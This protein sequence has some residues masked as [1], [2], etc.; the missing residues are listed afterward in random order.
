MFQPR[1]DSVDIDLSALSEGQQS[2]FYLALVAAVFDVERQVNLLRQSPP[3]IKHNSESLSPESVNVE[4][5]TDD[6]AGF[7]VDQLNIPA[8]TIFE[9]EE[10]E[11]HLAPIIWAE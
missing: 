8:L 3:T 9:I 6:A 10:P 4:T 5:T 2:L 7:N 11:N 1:D